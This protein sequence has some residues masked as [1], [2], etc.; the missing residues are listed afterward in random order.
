MVHDCRS[1]SGAPPRFK[2]DQPEM[3]E[4]ASGFAT[5]TPVSYQLLA[6]HSHAG[7]EPACGPGGLLLRSHEQ[8]AGRAGV[9]HGVGPCGGAGLARRK[10]MDGVV[11]MG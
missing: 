5:A 7:V 1:Y 8:R 2:R 3:N 4:C 11:G 9:Q 10:W 6:P